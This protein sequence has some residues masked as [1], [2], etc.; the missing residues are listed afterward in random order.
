VTSH[1]HAV[2]F[3][4]LIPGTD[5]PQIDLS[6]VGPGRYE[7]LNQFRYLDHE[8]GTITV[9]PFETDLTSV[10]FYDSW[11]TPQLGPHT[12]A[13]ILHDA[14]IGSPA[15]SVVG[16]NQPDDH[17]ADRIFHDALRS[18]GV[19]VFRRRTMWSA[20]KVLGTG[21]RLDQ[22]WVVPWLLVLLA[23]A[24][25]HFLEVIDAVDWLPWIGGWQLWLEWPVAALS[26][27]VVGVAASVLLAAARPNYFGAALMQS[28]LFA[29]AFVPVLAMLP[30]L[31][32]IRVIGLVMKLLRL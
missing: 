3:V 5:T 6:R 2:Y 7:L 8:F 18:L 9:H 27:L 13:A 23:S 10:R 32:V 22:L 1:P 16:M 25:V 12:P 28:L 15:F 31:I 11:I 4:D 30:A 20:A 17:D 29:L 21:L 19:G 26:T 14:M 24:A